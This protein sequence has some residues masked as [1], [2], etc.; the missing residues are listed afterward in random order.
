MT[1]AHKPP[2]HTPGTPVVE[3]KSVSKYFPDPGDSKQRLVT[4]RE[5]SLTIEDAPKG[6]FVVLLGPS[7][8]GKSTILSMMGGLLAPDDGEVW[9]LGKRVQGPNPYAVTVFQSYTCFPWLTARGNVEFGLRIWGVR[10]R[11]KRRELAAESLTKVGLGDKMEAYP[12]ELSGGQQQRVA[13]ARTLAVRPPIVLMDEPF[14]ALDAQTRASMQE[15]LTGLWLEL[16][17]LIVFITHDITEAIL[18]G[19][20]IVMLSARPATV[21]GDVRVEFP[22]PRAAELVYD[23]RFHELSEE[24]IRLLKA[25]PNKGEVRVSV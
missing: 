19:D 11:E 5:I 8:C 24:L 15:M 22:R 17:N 23:P 14:G 20:R 16:D 6:E 12:W 18:L 1:D 9:T 21:V 7:G 13:I 2:A 3:L 10:Q 4:V 25:T